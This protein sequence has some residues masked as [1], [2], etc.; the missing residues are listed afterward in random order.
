VSNRR[1]I[2]PL[3]VLGGA[4][5]EVA[6]ERELAVTAGFRDGEHPGRDLMTMFRV[7]A[8]RAEA[9]Q[10]AECEAQRPRVTCGFAEHARALVGSAA[11]GM[12]D[13]P[14]GPE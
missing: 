12:C 7:P 13:T 5:L 11:L 4:E 14:C 6:E 9:R 8:V 10:A 1:W 2:P 3:P